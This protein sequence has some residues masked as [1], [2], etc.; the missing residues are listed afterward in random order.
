MNAKTHSGQIYVYEQAFG[1]SPVLNELSQLRALADYSEEAMTLADETLQGLE[2]R[3]TSFFRACDE[4]VL[5]AILK[6]PDPPDPAPD[7]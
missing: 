1:P 4:I 3:A 5:E 2:E 6:G 7:V